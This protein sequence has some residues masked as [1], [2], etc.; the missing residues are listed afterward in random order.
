MKQRRIVGTAVWTLAAAMAV[1]G[2]D[3]SKGSRQ[4]PIFSED[5]GGNGGNG[6]TSGG[7]DGGSGGGGLDDGNGGGGGDGTTG[8]GN[9]QIQA[10]QKNDAFVNCDEAAA[11]ENFGFSETSVPVELSDVVVVAPKFD[12]YTHKTDPAKSLDGYFIMEGG[13]GPWSGILL[14]VPRDK[15]VTLAVGDI[16]DVSGEAVDYFCMTQVKASAV[17]KTGTASQMPPATDVDAAELAD[18]I[19]GEQWE[20]VLVRVPNGSIS[21][22]RNNFGEFLL[23]GALKVDDLYDYSYVAALGNVVSVSGV[24]HYTFSERK[25]EPRS[26]ADLVAGGGGGGDDAT[27]GD[28]GGGGG[29]SS[30]YDIQHGAASLDCAQPEGSQTVNPAV[31]IEGVVASPAFSVSEKLDGYFVSDGKGGPYSGVQVVVPVD[32][33]VTLQ[34]GDAISLTGKWV[35]YYCATQI[36]ASSVTVTDSGVAL[37]A[38]D[39]VAPDAISNGG[40]LSEAYEGVY[41]QVSNVTVTNPDAGFGEWEVDGVLLVDDLFDYAYTPKIGDKLGALRGFVS[42]GFGNFKLLPSRDEDIELGG[43]GGGNDGGNLPDGISGGDTIAAIQQASPSV[44]CTQDG[45]VNV[46]DVSLA[47]VV[48]T[49]PKLVVGNNDGW[50]V[51]D[52]AGGPYSGVMITIAKDAGANLKPGDELTL[53]GEWVEYYCNTEIDVDQFEVTASGVATPAP[54]PVYAS[55]LTGDGAEQWEGVVVL[56]EGVTVKTAADQYGVFEVQDASGAVQIDDDFKPGYTAVV[57]QTID[58]LAGPV[59]W[60]FG[61]F[62]VTPRSMADFGATGGGE[63]AGGG[64]D[65]GG[66][67]GGT[68]IEDLQTSAASTTCSKPSASAEIGKVS[69]EGLTVVSKKGYAG[70]NLDGWQLMSP[71]NGPNAGVFLIAKSTLGLALAPGDVVDVQASH[72][73]HYCLTELFADSVTVVTKGAAPSLT[74]VSATLAQLAAGAED[75]E[76][77]LVKVT[78]VTAEAPDQYGDFAIGQGILVDDTFYGFKS[79]AGQQ[80]ESVTGFLSYSFSAWRI[81]PRDAADVKLP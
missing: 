81:L 37:P 24:M 79:Q 72:K 49:S 36:T 47:G 31:T 56:L 5:A 66:G 58:A 8:G 9:G 4:N 69:L 30:I 27:V 10:I 14:A 3:T 65:I 44:D 78:N 34:I 2:C 38:A 46:G 55:D 57:G 61:S 35:E 45:F 32:L 59:R 71:P 67:G 48:V 6:D 43:G 7:K 50:Y 1:T 12:L 29:G 63:D 52:P 76:G 15:A 54:E 60:S 64:T 53:T 77:T 80:I 62:K 40:D 26:D 19:G 75:L 13:G 22:A 70:S 23:D 28:G 41:V 16:V 73:E 33:G 17:K 21:E 51:A 11:S 68:T 42:Y 74:P 20:A 25:L 18:A 39:D